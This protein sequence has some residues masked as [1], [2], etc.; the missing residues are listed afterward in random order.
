MDGEFAAQVDVLNDS[1][2]TGGTVRRVSTVDGVD[3]VNLRAKLRKRQ[4]EEAY[5]ELTS[6][7]DRGEFIPPDSLVITVLDEEFDH[8]IDEITDQLGLTMQV[9]V[10]G[11]AVSGADGEKLLLG[12]LEQRMPP[13][14]RLLPESAVFER[15][16]VISASPE[17]AL[18]R[19][20]VRAASAPAID[21]QMVSAAIAGKTVEAAREY[22]AK[23]FNL[24]SEPMIEL[25]GSLT[26]RLPWWAGRIGVRVTTG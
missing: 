4:Q 6:A 18:F 5:G 12:L 3:K 16:E 11:L 8:K 9:E 10:S 24:R 15:G 21:A 13:G 25:A 17:E 22:L 20:N 7:L 26:Q 23:Q 2:T 14:Y 1:R 19:M